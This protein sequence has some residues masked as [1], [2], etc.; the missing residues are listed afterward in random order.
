MV[1]MVTT[2][3]DGCHGCHRQASINIDQLGISFVI[4]VFCLYS[5][6][7]RIYLR[8]IKDYLG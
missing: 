5:L 4:G 7:V 2:R 6:L 3:E 1:T 8:M